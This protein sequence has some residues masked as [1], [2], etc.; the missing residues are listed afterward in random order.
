MKRYLLALF[1]SLFTT[2]ASA[3]ISNPYGLMDTQLNSLTTN[4][5]TGTKNALDVELVISG[6]VIDPRTRTWTLLNSTDSITTFQGTSPWVENLTQFG[7]TNLSTGV[8]NSGAGIP[9]VTV[10]SDSSITNITGTVSLPTGASTLAAQNTG[11][12]SLAAINVLQSSGGAKTQVV[13]A[14][15]NVQPV[16]DVAARKIFTAT[17]DGTNTQAVKAAST[18]PV[19]TDPSA[20]VSISSNYAS[21][22]ASTGTAISVGVASTSVLASNTARAGAVFT[23]T[24]NAIISC[25]TG[26]AVLR[27]GITL[28]P[29]GD[30]SM[31]PYTFTQGAINCIASAAASNLAVQE[32]TK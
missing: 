18:S 25:T 16:G 6:S 11:N 22:T 10:S 30:W 8:G 13:D 9:R 15:G 17:T 26:T 20:V 31:D 7:G 4:L 28:Y 2:N 29:G 1:L 24:S 19:S 14:S 5:F 32:F 23:N 21:L 27:S 3:D 12:T